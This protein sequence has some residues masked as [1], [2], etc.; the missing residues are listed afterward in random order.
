MKTVKIFF[1]VGLGNTRSEVRDGMALVFVDSFKEISSFGGCQWPSLAVEIAG[2]LSFGS[3]EVPLPGDVAVHHIRT[4]FVIAFDHW[5]EEGG[6]VDV[7]QQEDKDR[8]HYYLE[9]QA[10]E[11]GPPETPSFL[12][13]VIVQRDAVVPVLQPVFA[14]AIFSVGHVEGH[15]K[16][17]AGHKDQLESPEARVADWEVV[18]VTDILATGLPG[19][20][21]KVLLLIAPHLLASHQEDQKPENEDDCKPDATERSRVLVHSAHEA[22]EEGPV[23]GVVLDTGLDPH[24]EKNA[25]LSAEIPM[26]WTRRTEQWLLNVALITAAFLARAEGEGGILDKGKH[27]LILQLQSL[28]AAG[29]SEHLD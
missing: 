8:I 2:S 4:R 25:P 15:E 28:A 29:D 5:R 19:V 11:V 10:E 9:Q 13:R 14:L 1:S 17:R 18:V 7:E 24:K 20:A 27:R 16:G 22:L 21:V 12:A 26:A 3:S 23:H 6:L